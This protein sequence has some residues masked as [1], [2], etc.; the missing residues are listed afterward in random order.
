MHRMCPLSGSSSYLPRSFYQ[1]VRHS[2]LLPIK[3]EIVGA[4]FERQS[5]LPVPVLIGAIE[6]C[7]RPCPS[8]SMLFSSDLA[9]SQD[10]MLFAAWFFILIQDSSLFISHSPHSWQCYEGMS[11]SSFI[12]LLSII[13]ESWHDHTGAVQL[14]EQICSFL[15]LRGYSEYACAIILKIKGRRS[16]SRAHL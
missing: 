12:C 1:G 3:T 5:W 4:R 14:L 13:N 9:N 10:L 16:S 6:I 11:I 2:S 8:L 7:Q 15:L